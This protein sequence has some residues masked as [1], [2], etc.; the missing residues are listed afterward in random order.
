[1]KEMLNV[2]SSCLKTFPKKRGQ[3]LKVSQRDSMWVS[4]KWQWKTI[5][6]MIYKACIVLNAIQRK[7]IFE[8]DW[9]FE[10]STASFY[11]DHGKSAF[12]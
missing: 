9:G 5:L 3:N 1:M 11:Q 7:I 8:L 4:A 10:L 2:V 6:T 12:L